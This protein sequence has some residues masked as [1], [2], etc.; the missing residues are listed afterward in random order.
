VPERPSLPPV[1]GPPLRPGVPP[2]PPRGDLPGRGI[3]RPGA[4][5]PVT[6]PPSVAQPGIPRPPQGGARPPQ[7]PP[8]RGPSSGPIA[9]TRFTVSIEGRDVAVARVSPP[10][11]LVDRGS[12]Q[13]ESLG[14]RHPLVWSGGPASGAVVLERAFDGD[15]TFYAWRRRAATHDVK[16][17]HAATRDVE[18]A[19]LDAAGE[20][21]ATMLLH[22]A[23]PVRWSGPALDAN[24]ASVATE[25]LELVYADLL[26]R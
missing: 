18:V 23:W 15:T 14:D 22:R 8:Q 10:H 11:L 17:Q 4:S 9:G 25:S 16:A 12:L 1:G 2:Q 26:M 20:V 13:L 7:E 19:V 6:A 3:P 21:V 24:E 5:R